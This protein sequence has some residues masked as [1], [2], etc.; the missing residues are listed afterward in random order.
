MLSYIFQKRETKQKVRIFFRREVRLFPLIFFFVLKGKKWFI[1][2][3]YS[4]PS[5]LL[6]RHLLSLRWRAKNHLILITAITVNCYCWKPPFFLSSAV[7]LGPF[8]PCDNPD[9]RLY[10]VHLLSLFSIGKKS[11]IAILGFIL[12]CPHLSEKKILSIFTSLKG[13][14][15]SFNKK[16][17][18]IDYH[19]GDWTVDT[20]SM[21]YKV[22]GF[23]DR[24]LIF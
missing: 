8:I 1:F 12:S 9:F 24:F 11:P 7:W 3:V 20:N 16:K 22:S 18:E 17:I 19:H 13:S 5:I 15:K 2:V 6:F 14:K 23:F 21:N 4:L 10:F